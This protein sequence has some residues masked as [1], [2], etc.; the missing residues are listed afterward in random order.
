MTIAVPSYNQGRFLDLALG[1]IFEQGVPAEVFVLDGGSTDGTRKIIEKW[2]PLLAGWRSHPDDGQS[3]A[4]NE[5]IALGSAPYV[6]WLNS[7]DYYMRNGL[8]ALIAALEENSHAPVA[9]GRALNERVETAERSPVWVQPFSAEALALRCIISQP[10]ALIRRS[11]WEAVNG[12]DASL[13]MAMDYDL[14]WRLYRYGGE[15]AFVDQA[16]AVSRDHAE[17]KTNTNRKLHYSEA[18]MTVR[19]HYG[20]VPLKWY[21]YQPYAVWLKQVVSYLRLRGK[22]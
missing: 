15:F 13:H 20:K 8:K 10:A 1:S 18:I 14:W 21:L 22:D 2:E 12:T 4:V 9:Y 3:A 19:S 6:T 11:A 16:I 17:T 5:G 7:D